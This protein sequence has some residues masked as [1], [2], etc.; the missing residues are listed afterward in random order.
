MH[1]KTG[2][3]TVYNALNKNLIV[4]GKGLAG[5]LTTKDGRHLAF[6]LYVNAVPVTRDDPEAVTKI[7]GQGLGEIAAAAYDS[8]R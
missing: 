3:F 6:A 2:T 7:A 4:T 8:P 1:A 5:Y